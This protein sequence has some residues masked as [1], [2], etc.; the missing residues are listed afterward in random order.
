MTWTRSWSRPPPQG[1]AR[2]WP[3]YPG[4]YEVSRFVSAPANGR[5][6]AQSVSPAGEALGIT[7]SEL[8]RQV[9]QAFYGEEV[10]RVQRGREKTSGSWCVF[11]EDERRSLDSLYALRIRTNGRRCRAVSN[12]RRSNRTVAGVAARFRERAVSRSVNV[13]AKCRSDAGRRPPQCL[14]TVARRCCLP[15]TRSRS[16]SGL[17]YTL[18]QR[19]ATATGSGRPVGARCSFWRSV[20]D[21]RPARD[22]ATHSYLQPLIVMSMLPFAFMSARSWGHRD[23]EAASAAFLGLSMAS[24]FGMRWPRRAWW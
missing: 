20:R 12:R 9:R 10:Q 22:S 21:F 19:A 3:N 14:R 11:T 24:V 23:H 6:A 4:V 7:L 1:F 18:D 15:M 13:T 2:H 8:G 5:V 16:Y 17:S